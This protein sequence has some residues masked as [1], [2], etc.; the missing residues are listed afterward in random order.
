MRR[1]GIL[2]AFGAVL[3]S[4]AAMAKAKITLVASFSVLGDMVSR[5][6]GDRAEVVTLVG[7]NGDA[8]TYEPSPGDVKELAAAR[9]VFVNGLGL[10]PWMERLALSAGYT[11]P[12]VTASEGV[13]TRTMDED[14]ATVIDPHAWQDLRNGQI[15]VRNIVR[16]LSEADAANAEFYRRSGDAYAAEMTLLDREVRQQIATVPSQKRRVITSHDAFGYFGAAYGVEFLAPEGLSTE[17][18]A[19][20]GDLAR[21]MDQIRREG[22]KAL[23]LENISD[24][25]MMEMIASETGTKLGGALYSDALSPPGGQAPHYTD[26]FRNNVPKLVA[27]MAEN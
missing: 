20:A 27:A 16:A 21:L 2:A 18:E 14:G 24:P 22:I 5:I 3:L 11:G 10:E 8:H 7:P 19:S 23:F 12:L 17:A 6:A 1:R 9:L 13:A 26:M 15:Y 25:R 4:P